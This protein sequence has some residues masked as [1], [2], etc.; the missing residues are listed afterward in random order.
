[1]SALE[2]RRAQGWGRVTT[3]LGSDTFRCENCE[4]SKGTTRILWLLGHALI[5]VC[6][7]CEKEL[8]G[9][10]KDAGGGEVE[11]R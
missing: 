5:R 8:L 10:W 9:V 2:S 6:L 3:A 1:M 4:K 11:R 7:P